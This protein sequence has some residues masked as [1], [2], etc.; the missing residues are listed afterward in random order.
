[1]I[2]KAESLKE[3][4]RQTFLGYVENTHLCTSAKQN[5]NVKRTMTQRKKFLLY[6]IKALLTI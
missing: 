5:L 3:K 4:G 6:M 2:Q 1:M